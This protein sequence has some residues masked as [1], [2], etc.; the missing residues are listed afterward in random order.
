[1]SNEPQPAEDPESVPSSSPSRVVIALV[2][3]S[4]VRVSVADH[5]RTRSNEV[6]LQSELL[7]DAGLDRAL[8][9]LSIDPSYSGERWEVPADSLRAESSENKTAAVVTIEVVGSPGESRRKLK[10]QADYPPDPPRRV[11]SSRE[12]MLP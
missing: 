7:A 2:A 4:L 1:M 9:K 12:I 5:Q 11:R 3:A 10:V 8:A 6:A